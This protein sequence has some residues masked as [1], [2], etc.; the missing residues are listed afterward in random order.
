MISNQITEYQVRFFKS[1]AVLVALTIAMNFL[2]HIVEAKL[3]QSQL[4]VWTQSIS[5]HGCI[6]DSKM[7]FQS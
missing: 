5:N 2:Y 7:A 1:T 6:F 3:D 4:Q